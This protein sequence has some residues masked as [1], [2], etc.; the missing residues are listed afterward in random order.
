MTWGGKRAGAGRKKG[1]IS[2]ATRLRQEFPATGLQEGI[3]PLQ[4]MLEAMR[5]AYAQGG[6]NAAFPFAVAAAPYFHALATTE[7]NG[8]CSPSRQRPAN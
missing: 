1:S 4:I 2:A 3:V 8:Q 5:E 6:A 7:F